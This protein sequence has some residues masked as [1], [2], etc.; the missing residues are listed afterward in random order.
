MNLKEDPKLH[1]R[2]ISPTKKRRRKSYG[3]EKDVEKNTSS[4]ETTNGTSASHQEVLRGENG[5]QVE[6]EKKKI[7]IMKSNQ[8]RKVVQIELE[9]EDEVEMSSI[10]PFCQLSFPSVSALTF[11]RLMKHSK[12][13]NSKDSNSKKTSPDSSISK[14]KTSNDS[15]IIQKEVVE[16]KVNTELKPKPRKPKV[17]SI[18][19]RRPLRSTQNKTLEL[20]RKTTRSGFDWSNW[21]IKK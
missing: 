12:N 5:S 19:N 9:D 21:A 15:K 2:L 20:S 14:T 13:S 7:K 1:R 4:D 18:N 8:N 17:H 11:H 3:L 6:Q 10:C 16:M